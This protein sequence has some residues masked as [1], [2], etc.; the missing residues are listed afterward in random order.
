MCGE[1]IFV[2]PCT[3]VGLHKDRLGIPA[4]MLHCAFWHQKLVLFSNAW[5]NRGKEGQPHVTLRQD[6]NTEKF[7]RPNI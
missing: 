5:S 6:G 2:S 4:S 7:S 1:D 3:C